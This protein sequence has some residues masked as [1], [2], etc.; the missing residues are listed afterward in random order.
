MLIERFAN[1]F[2]LIQ[3]PF[4]L[5]GNDDIRPHRNLEYHNY[6]KS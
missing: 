4:L 6:K 3:H 5:T 1:K 2:N